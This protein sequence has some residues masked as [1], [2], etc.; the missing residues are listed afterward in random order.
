MKTSNL[1]PRWV[2][3]WGEKS[4]LGSW[5]T[6]SSHNQKGTIL[7]AIELQWP[8]QE[9]RPTTFKTDGYPQREN[10]RQVKLV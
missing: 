9:P 7:K 2:Q 8:S 5:V 6:N 3:F 4:Q 10:Y 1:T